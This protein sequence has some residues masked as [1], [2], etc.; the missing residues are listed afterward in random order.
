MVIAAILCAIAI[1]LWAFSTFLIT[2]SIPAAYASH[3]R[4]PHCSVRTAELA[5][6]CGTQHSH[7][8]CSPMYWVDCDDDA[9]VDLRAFG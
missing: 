9:Y 7:D 3:F 1:R 4:V 6:F 2:M 5:L 8:H